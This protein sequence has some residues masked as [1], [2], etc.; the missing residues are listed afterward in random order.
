MRYVYRILVG[1]L[2]RK[3]PFPKPV[4]RRV[5]TVEVY[6]KEK[7]WKMSTGFFWLKVGRSDVLM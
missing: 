2:Y 1:E 6:H 3:R 4:H 5:D 7:E